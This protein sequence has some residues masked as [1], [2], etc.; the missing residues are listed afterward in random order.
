MN[1]Y[2]NAK[3]DYINNKDYLSF[4]KGIQD[5]FKPFDTTTISDLKTVNANLE[6][7]VDNEEQYNR[8]V[9]K[10]NKENDEIIKKNF[11]YKDT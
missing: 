7:I 11:I 5:I 4:Y 8:Y 9:L 2:K 6:T 1:I 10:I 3:N